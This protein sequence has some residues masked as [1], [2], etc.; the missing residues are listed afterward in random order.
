MAIFF[1]QGFVL[2]DNPKKPIV[3][4]TAVIVQQVTV[5]AYWPRD[6]GPC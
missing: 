4:V 6:A 5:T 1:S 2:E 3:C